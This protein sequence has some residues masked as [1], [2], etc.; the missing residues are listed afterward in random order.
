M[1][2]ARV[3]SGHLK[4]EDLINMSTDELAS[5]EL[6]HLRKQVQ[7]E[8]TKNIVLAGPSNGGSQSE[9]S[10]DIDWARK[11]K[12]DSP[13]RSFN[14]STQL[15]DE[16]DLNA[17]PPPS[18][19]SI[20]QEASKLEV[21]PPPV[22][23]SS[24]KSA[25]HSKVFSTKIEHGSSTSRTSQDNHDHG[26][27]VISQSG[28]ESFLITITRLRLSFTTKLFIE[29]SCPYQVDNFLPS[30]LIEK[31]RITLDE[32]NKFISDKMKSGRWNIVHLK[33]SHITGDADM[34][35]YKRLYK[36][37][38]SLDRICM[39][40]ATDSTKVFLVTPKFLR[41]CK[42]MTSVQNLSRSSTYAVVLT[43]DKLLP[44]LP[45]NN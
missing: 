10:V 9:S 35:A 5:K 17:P 27:H 13:I 11:V 23:P 22:F 28:T 41:V 14:K 18:S 4:T 37:Y 38:E 33:L 30:S 45:S 3:L 43:K 39:I 15:K 7:Q 6:S 1:L 12:I 40:N 19:Q 44:A 34:N 20:Q 36:E 31:G 29:Q 8:A 32:F 25:R 24:T 42:C 2:A 21:P 26:H 16:E